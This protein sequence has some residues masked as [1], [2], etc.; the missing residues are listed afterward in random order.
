MSVPLSFLLGTAMAFLAGE[1]VEWLPGEAR[2]LDLLFGCAFLPLPMLWV[3]LAGR[4]LLAA[5][6]AGR[7]P[8]FAARLALRLALLTVPL[9][10]A[11]LVGLG[12]WHDHVERL[13]PDSH[14]A[15]FALLLLPA[16]LL[17]AQFRIAVA[18]LTS[19]VLAQRAEV[20][21]PFE[22]G[23]APMVAL[24][25]VCALLLGVAMDLAAFSPSLHVFF[26][27]TALGTTLG[28]LL[29]VAGGSASLPLLFRFLLPTSRRLPERIAVE[30]REIAARLG[31]RPSGLL[32]LDTGLRIVNAALVGPLRWP[33]YLVLTDGILTYLDAPT[34][35]GVVAH[36][37]GH[38]RAGHPALI[39]LV[40][41]VLPILLVEPVAQLQLEAVDPWLLIGAGAA[42]MAIHG[43]RASFRHPS[44]VDRVQELVAHA[45]DPRRGLRFRR[46]GRR[47]RIGLGLFGATVIVLSALAHA[48]AFAGD[49]AT[50]ALYT[51]RFDE[52]RTWLDSAPQ[53]D[54][55]AA[56]LRLDLDA[57]DA[58]RLSAANPH[59]TRT[60]LAD[61]ALARA[62]EFAARGELAAARPY[63][64]LALA[65]PRD[66]PVRL[67]AWLWSLAAVDGDGERVE[68]IATHLLALSDTPPVLRD[69][70]ARTR[71]AR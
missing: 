52:A 15:R 10:V 46:R 11:A 21:L 28:L 18:R 19:R 6:R 38:A 64:A 9:C 57:A 67:S 58:L 40:I 44:E 42:A 34:L 71:S 62:I 23:T 63:F 20:D 50:H 26:G 49:M 39:V 14:T 37:V 2:F 3:T 60:A 53:D 33:R 24:V 27:A 70:I 55:R 51:S 4:A 54:P 7:R 29:L 35:R 56:D 45:N 59:T 68:R 16:A 8:G 22:G 61:P 69:A 47:L 65:I 30:V 32:A 5:Q 31:F 43:F 12:G 48:R 66:D 17:E 1:T 25:V 41:L 36:E 13:A